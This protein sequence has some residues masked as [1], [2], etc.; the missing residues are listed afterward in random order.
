MHWL[1][2]DAPEMVRLVWI[3]AVEMMCVRSVW[4]E[5]GLREERRDDLRAIG[6]G[7]G[8]SEGEREVGSLREAVGICRC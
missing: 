4:A 2:M 8:V 6:M 5:R 1:V 3:V 7:E